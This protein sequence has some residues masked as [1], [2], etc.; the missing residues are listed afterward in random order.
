VSATTQ[1]GHYSVAGNTVTAGFRNLNN[2]DLTGF[3]GSSVITFT[4]PKTCILADVGFIGNA[5]VTNDSG[6][7]NPPYPV[8]TNGSNK[9]FMQR[10]GTAGLLSEADLTSGTSD[11]AHFTLTYIWE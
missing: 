1:T 4:L 6:S 10:A 5:I 9:S 11:V 8:T 2:I 3:P 7:A